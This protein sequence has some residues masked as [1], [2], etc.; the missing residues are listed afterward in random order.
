MA[1]CCTPSSRCSPDYRESYPRDVA[2]FLDRHNHPQGL[3]DYADLD[4]RLA[5]KISVSVKLQLASGLDSHQLRLKVF[6]L[7]QPQMTAKKYRRHPAQQLELVQFAD[8]TD[9]QQAIIGQRARSYFHSAA[10]TM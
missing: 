5:G 3:V 7:L 9:V 4:R 10:I 8:H 2:P 1:P 6:H